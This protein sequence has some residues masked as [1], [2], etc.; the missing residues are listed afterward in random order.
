[1]GIRHYRVKYGDTLQKLAKRFYD[2][3]ELGP[4]IYQHNR[5]N[6]QNPNVLYPGQ[7]LTIPYISPLAKMVAD[8]V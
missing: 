4:Y 8:F 3:G 7:I 2:N 5:H 1:M 6:I